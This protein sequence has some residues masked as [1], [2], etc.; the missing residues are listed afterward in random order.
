MVA[1]KRQFFKNKG[2]GCGSVSRKVASDSIGS[3]PDNGK[4]YVECS[5]S[6][7]FIEKTQLKKIR[8]VNG[9]FK[10]T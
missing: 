9:P 8:A 6:T 4:T 1:E 10:R 7:V 3:N 5:L 2:N